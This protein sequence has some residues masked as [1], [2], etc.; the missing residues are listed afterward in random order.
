MNRVF[1]LIKSILKIGDR[2]N[3]QQACDRPIQ[4]S[5]TSIY[6]CVPL[7]NTLRTLR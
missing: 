6:L 5:N 1:L 2:I 4:T 3:H 7:R